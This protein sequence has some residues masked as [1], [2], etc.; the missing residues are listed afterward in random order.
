MSFK[1]EVVQWLCDNG[2]SSLDVELNSDFYYSTG[3]DIDFNYVDECVI[4]IGVDRFDE[5]DKWFEQFL[6]E[7]GLEWMDLG[8]VLPFIHELGHYNTVY[9]FSNSERLAMYY[10]K[11]WIFSDEDTTMEEMFKYWEMPD[12]FA[13]NVW[14]VNFIN[15]NISEVE[16][17]VNIF[18]KYQMM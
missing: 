2:F 15:N 12:E 18:L 7:Y 5:I 17:L 11:F 9:S 14:A 6:Y 1:S 4:N 13:A 3:E 8:R 16:R 10:N